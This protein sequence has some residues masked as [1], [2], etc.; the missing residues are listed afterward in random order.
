MIR[1]ST[2]PGPGDN[3][4]RRGIGCA[5]LGSILATPT[6]KLALTMAKELIGFPCHLTQHSGGFCHYPDRLDEVTPVMNTAMKERT[7]VEW[8]SSHSTRL[9]L[10]VDVLALGMLAL[11]KGFALLDKHYGERLTLA[12]I[13][14][15]RHGV[16][17]M[18][19]RADMDRRVPDRKSRADVD[20]RSPRASTISSSRSRSCAPVRSSATWCILICADGRASRTSSYPS[21]ELEAVLMKTLGVPLFQEQAMKPSSLR[22]SRPRKPTSCAARWRRFVDPAQLETL[23]A[24]MIEGMVANGYQREFAERAASIRFEGFGEYGFPESHAASFALLVYDFCWMKRPPGCFA[25]AD[26]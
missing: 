8:T 4:D 3:P 14:P 12:N 15:E 20:V 22:V 5:R 26:G 2:G 7:M 24:K 18:I 6:L 9:V 13:P 1:R 17:A 23:Q 16:Y 10:K 11:S 19:Q 25:A 21:K